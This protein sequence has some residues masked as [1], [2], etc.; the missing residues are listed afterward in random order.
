MGRTWSRR[1]AILERLLPYINT[2]NYTEFEGFIVFGAST[3]EE[4][5]EELARPPNQR[6]DQTRWDAVS[7]FLS[8][9]KVH[10]GREQVGKR[11][12][13]GHT[14]SFKSDALNGLSATDIRWLHK[15]LEGALPGVQA[16]AERS[17]MPSDATEEDAIDAAIAEELL[18]KLPKAVNR[19]A[20]L[21]QMS[22]EHVPDKDLRRYFDEAHRCYLYGF[23]VACAV[24]CR[25]ILE[26]ALKS[27]CDPKCVIERQLPSGESYFKA[28]VEKAR[29]DHLLED[30]RP[31]C[32]INAREAGR[33]AIHN[34]PKFQQNWESK[35]GEVLD[36]TRKVLLDLFRS[37]PKL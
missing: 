17:R 1:A 13:L 8:D 29:K 9:F 23:S 35:L 7:K 28:L 12:S 5:F 18:G 3:V 6:E 30:D 33:F 16:A 2:G 19:A 37:R 4:V 11:L 22:L 15:L 14:P 26:C 21:D 27:V 20:H 10:G 36:G 32:A 34:F 24:L 31:K 25:A